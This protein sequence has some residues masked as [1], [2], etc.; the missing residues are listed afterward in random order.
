[1]A[2]LIAF[3]DISM[4][5]VLDYDFSRLSGIEMWMERMKKI[6]E[7]GKANEVFVKAQKGMKETLR[8]TQAKL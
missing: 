4:L 1:M 8:N 6:P 5:E 3:F 2:D 7:V